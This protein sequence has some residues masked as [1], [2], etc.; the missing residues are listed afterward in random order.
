MPGILLVTPEQ[1][2]QRQTKLRR[3]DAVE[4]EVER[5]IRVGQG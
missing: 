3:G 2:L 4:N 1:L 5:V